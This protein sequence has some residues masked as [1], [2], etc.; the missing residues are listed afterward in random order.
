MDAYLERNVEELSLAELFNAIDRQNYHLRNMRQANNLYDR[1]DFYHRHVNKRKYNFRELEARL[2][3]LETKRIELINERRRRFERG[4]SLHDLLQAYWNQGSLDMYVS[5]QSEL[6]QWR[7]RP[8]FERDLATV[9]AEERERMR[10]DLHFLQGG[11]LTRV[12]NAEFTDPDRIGHRLREVEE[13]ERR[14]AAMMATSAR[15]GGGSRLRN[16][17]PEVLRSIVLN[18]GAQP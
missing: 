15:L 8:L 17:D 9:N 12:V 2:R 14:L 4:M 1:D 13:P 7:L 16:L 5:W 18:R 11:G 3:E 6:V 10:E